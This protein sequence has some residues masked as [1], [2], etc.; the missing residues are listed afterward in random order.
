M[1]RAWSRKERRR[2]P[3]FAVRGANAVL[4]P[5]GN[6]LLTDS[7]NRALGAVNLSVGGA[8]L[9]TRGPIPLGAAVRVTL[10]FEKPRGRIDARGEVRWSR[11]NPGAGRGAHAGVM[12]VGLPP[13]QARK[14]RRL[15]KESSRA[16]RKAPKPR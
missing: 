8:R 13:A 1:K 4:T 16:G 5:E 15:G 2:H 9:R 7:G 10:E 14:I 11:K 12:F 3:R 6:L